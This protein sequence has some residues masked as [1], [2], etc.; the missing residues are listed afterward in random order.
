[1]TVS[2][3]GEVD[4]AGAN[5]GRVER[6]L[7]R[8]DRRAPG[9]L[10]PSAGGLADRRAA[11]LRHLDRLARGRGGV[12]QCSQLVVSDAAVRLEA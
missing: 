8:V 4:R 12:R 2:L 6:V 3:D 10:V 1:M 5:G 11:P 7:G 9:Q